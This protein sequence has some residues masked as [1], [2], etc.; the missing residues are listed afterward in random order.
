MNA[1]Y[2]KKE[3]RQA[4]AMS[5][6]I[7]ILGSL[8]ISESA[9]DERPIPDPG[10]TGVTMVVIPNHASY[11]YGIGGFTGNNANAPF[12]SAFGSCGLQR[13]VN[14]LWPINSTIFLNKEFDLPD[15]ARNLRVQLSVDNDAE[16]RING[17]LIGSVTHVDCPLVDEWLLM[18]S[19]SILNIGG[20]NTIGVRARDRGGESFIDL[21]VL[22]DV[23]PVFPE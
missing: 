23:F 17:A 3:L 16:V 14:T 19:D 18:A 13:S 6:L 8:T 2:I 21:R 11:Q 4:V 5:A 12:G 10:I 1:K 15:G 22:V 9:A 20:R 7:G